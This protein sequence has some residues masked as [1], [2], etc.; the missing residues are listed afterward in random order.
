MN[1]AIKLDGQAKSEKK[2]LQNLITTFTRIGPDAQPEQGAVIIQFLRNHKQWLHYPEAQQMMKLAS[3][4]IYGTKWWNV[5]N[6]PR[7]IQ[8]QRW[9]EKRTDEFYELAC[10][11][12][13]AKDLNSA[14]SSE[15]MTKVV[16]SSLCPEIF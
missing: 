10:H 16:K 7:P 14:I 2:A 12:A 1:Q 9:A 13:E 6:D 3:Q 5:L 4:A 15:Q 8:E 11:L